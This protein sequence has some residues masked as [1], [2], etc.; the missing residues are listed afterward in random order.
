MFVMAKKRSSKP[1]SPAK[2]TSR[3]SV[4]RP[5]FLARLHK[6]FGDKVIEPSG[7]EIISWDR[8]GR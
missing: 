1:K 4:K 3:K 5:D 2:K 6:I 8:E 7:A